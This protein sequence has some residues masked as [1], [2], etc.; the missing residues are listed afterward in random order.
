M[1][2]LVLSIIGLIVTVILKAKSS[3]AARYARN[4][5][6]LMLAAV[7]IVAFT[8]LFLFIEINPYDT[9]VSRILF[10]WGFFLERTISHAQL[11]W[12][13]VLTLFFYFTGLFCAAHWFMRWFYPRIQKPAD[14]AQTRP[15]TLRL[16]A[17]VMTLFVL[18]LAISISMVGIIHQT[19]WFLISPEPIVYKEVTEVYLNRVIM[20]TT[21][22]VQMA[23]EDYRVKNGF[24]LNHEGLTAEEL[25][26]YF[27]MEHYHNQANPNEP[28]RVWL[29]P[30]VPNDAG[31][32]GYEY[33][34]YGPDTYAVRG[35]TKEGL[36]KDNDKK[37]LILTNYQ[38]KR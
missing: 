21:H 2:F 5:T 11:D 16:T 8:S 12:G 26:K 15:W 9:L 28:N 10:G 6:L 14:D 35:Y 22:S 4:F 37:V 13:W 20:S 24:Y 34:T 33:G 36:L 1:D 19:I 7:V 3:P 25:T 17:K 23:A 32:V 27:N 29:V 18:F 30:G 31:E 38:G